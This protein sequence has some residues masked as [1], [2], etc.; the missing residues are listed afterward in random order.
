MAAAG[1]YLLASKPTNLPEPPVCEVS[2]P[3]GR[4]GLPLSMV[5]TDWR[6]PPLVRSVGTLP[7]SKVP[8]SGLT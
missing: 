7:L 5:R 6:E 4:V 3:C 8:R 1:L 2:I